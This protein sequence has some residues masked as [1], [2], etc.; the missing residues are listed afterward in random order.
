MVR[1]RMEE[2]PLG[3]EA[4]IRAVGAEP[5][6]ASLLGID[7]EKVRIVVD[8]SVTGTSN[9]V[10]GANEPDYHMRNFNW[11][12]DAASLKDNEKVA[13]GDIACA[14]EAE[15]LAAARASLPAA[16]LRC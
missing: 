10:V 14:R 16:P 11:D 8:N 1:L 2:E 4:A 7:S 9:L 12:R 13:V 15:G 3:V 5:G 6:Y